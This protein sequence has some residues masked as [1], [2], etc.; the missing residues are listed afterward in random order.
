VSFI[1]IGEGTDQHGKEI[2][3]SFLN[4]WATNHKQEIGYQTFQWG[5]EGEVNFCFSLSELNEK[6]QME[7]INGIKEKFKGHDLIKFTE[8]E[9]YPHRR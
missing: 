1:S 6:Q 4:E 9:P 8:N 2:L 7:F 3:D 5:R